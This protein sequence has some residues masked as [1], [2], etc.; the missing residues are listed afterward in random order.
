MYVVSSVTSFPT[1]NEN[2]T[3]F[4]R[5]AILLIR[6]HRAHDPMSEMN[7]F[8]FLRKRIGELLGL[9]REERK[10]SEVRMF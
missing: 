4:R 9:C 3:D 6:P 10:D 7:W 1:I 5:Q 2:T 8:N